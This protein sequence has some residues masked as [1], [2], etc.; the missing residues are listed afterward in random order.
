MR[1]QK[2]QPE[3]VLLDTVE[4]QVKL[5]DFGSAQEVELR[6]NGNT[7]AP[8]H[9]DSSPE[10]QA[11]EVISSGP[12]GTYT[13][14]WG[15]GVLLYVALRYVFW[16]E[17]VKMTVNITYLTS[18]GLS[19]FLDDSDEETTNNILRCD[20]SFPAEYFS[21]A[22][23]ESKDLVRRLLSVNPAQRPS[24]S[25]CLDSSSWLRASSDHDISSIHL[26]TLVRRRLKKLNTMA[27]MAFGP[28]P[29]R[30]L[31]QPPPL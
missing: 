4:N 25:F 14:M 27:P 3:N 6:F 23:S 7:T 31:P 11:P 28:S 16:V 26:S 15:F 19:P 8:T 5:I 13:D 12:V 10:F 1:Y 17:R 29:T 21:S 9:Q 20:F 24:A 30:I 2:L 22:S 18:S